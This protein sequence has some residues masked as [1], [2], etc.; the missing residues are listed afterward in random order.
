MNRSQLRIVV[1]AAVA[2]LAVSLAGAVFPGAIG[3]QTMSAS[4]GVFVEENTTLEDPPGPSGVDLSDTP[5][6]RAYYQFF[7]PRN[8]SAVTPPGAEGDTGGGADILPV[9]AAVGTAITALVGVGAVVWVRWLWSTPDDFGAARGTPDATD[10]AV[11]TPPGSI[12]D[13]DPSNDV[14]GAWVE[15]VRRVEVPRHGTMTPRELA[16]VAIEEGFDREAVESLTAVFET[17]RYGETPPSSEHESCAQAALDALSE[18][19]P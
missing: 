5:W 9:L 19:D 12:G 8:E 14:Y 11:T 18:G 2:V 6:L 7:E 17:V 10:P 3:S 16:R 1:V 4:S 13:L 15:L